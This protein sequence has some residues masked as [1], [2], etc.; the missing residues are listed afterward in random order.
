MIDTLKIF[1]ELKQALGEE[2]ARKLARVLTTLYTDL[3]NTATR[4][5]FAELR[6]VVRDL[7]EAQ[8][9]TEARIEELAEAQTRTEARIEELAQ[10]Q[11]RTEQRLEQLTI[12]VD[13]LAEAQRKTE[14]EVRLLA[15]QMRET[16]QQLGGLA[17]TVGYRLEDAAFKTLPNL[18]ARDFGVTVKDRLR[19]TFVLD[20]QGKHIEVNVFGGASKNGEKAF[21]VGEAKSQLNKND[22][23]QFIRRKLKRLEGAYDNLVPLLIAYMITSPDVEAYARQKGIGLYYS[24]DLE[25]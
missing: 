8:K 20:N 9:R 18:L 4:Q 1:E 14:E 19:R 6:E 24:F 21:V 23:D 25:A 3:Q 10:A 7:V 5:E 13:Q 16:R 22:I 17:M 12:R 15:R 11:E 2:P